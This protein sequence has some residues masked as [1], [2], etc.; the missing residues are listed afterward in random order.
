MCKAQRVHSNK[1][2]TTCGIAF[3]RCARRTVCAFHASATTWSLARGVRE[4]RNARRRAGR[5]HV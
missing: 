2:H 4:R 5:M 1:N 3:H